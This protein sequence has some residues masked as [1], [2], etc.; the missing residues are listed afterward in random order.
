MD[1][2]LSLSAIVAMDGSLLCAVGGRDCGTRGDGKRFSIPEQQF[3]QH[4]CRIHGSLA[5]AF[6]RSLSVG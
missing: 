6:R 4:L 1:T 5:V 2:E 3:Q